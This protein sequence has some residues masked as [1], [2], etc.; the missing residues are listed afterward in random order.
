MPLL[1]RHPRTPAPAPRPQVTTTA[2]RRH[3]RWLSAKLYGAAARQHEV[4]TEHLPLLIEGLPDGVDRWFFVRYRDP[5]P[6]LR[7]R[8]HGAPDVLHG[9]MA[10]AVLAWADRL[11]E[12]RLAGRLIFDGYEPETARYGGPDL[13]TAVERHFHH[14][15]LHVL[16]QLR[17]FPEGVP[18]DEKALLTAVN[19][20]DTV[21][22]V[23]GSHWPGWLLHTALDEACEPH[24]SYAH[25]NRREAWARYHRG[26]LTRP[27]SAGRS[28]ALGPPS[29]R[30][31]APSC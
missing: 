20:V 9:P 19:F 14:D 4:L 23:H 2:T 17:S 29:R 30:S 5:D 13:I 18:D 12:Q 8:F 6:H 7:L 31:G 15:S 10:R 25:R 27:E 21:R 24:R 11:R 22:Q 28:E 26:D 3:P 16:Q 1:P